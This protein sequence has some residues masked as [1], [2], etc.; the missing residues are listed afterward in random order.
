MIYSA[1]CNIENE[2]KT[3]SMF[4]VLF[5]SLTFSLSFSNREGFQLHFCR[6]R[7]F[8]I[9]EPHLFLSYA[10]DMAL[11][12]SF[13]PLPCLSAGYCQM[14]ESTMAAEDTGRNQRQTKTQKRFCSVQSCFKSDQIFCVGQ[15]SPHLKLIPTSCLTSIKGSGVIRVDTGRVWAAVSCPTA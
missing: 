9:P 5:P 10:C 2:Q 14:R 8:P 6:K 7:F 11:V 3:W 1:S 15:S 12:C 4:I 13:N